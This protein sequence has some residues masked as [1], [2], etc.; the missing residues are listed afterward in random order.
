M[1]RDLQLKE[2]ALNSLHLPI[3]VK[4]GFIGSVSLKVCVP[5]HYPVRVLPLVH[6]ALESAAMEK[7]SCQQTNYKDSPRD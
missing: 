7:K 4:A 3:S 1:L 2:E 5:P 6:C